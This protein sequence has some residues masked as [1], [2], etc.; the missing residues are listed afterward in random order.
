MD[1]EWD[2][3]KELENIRKHRVALAEAVD[4]F[5]DPQGLQL[6]DDRHSDIERRYYWAG[7]TSTGRILATWFTRRGTTIRIIGCA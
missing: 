6:V 1:F 4:A 3:S 7:Q 5:R 2:F